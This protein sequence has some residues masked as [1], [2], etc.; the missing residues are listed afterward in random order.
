MVKSF[1]KRLASDIL[2]QEV[3]RAVVHLKGVDS[4]YVRMVELC[5]RFRFAF[6]SAQPIR[7]VGERLGQRLDGHVTIQPCVAATVHYPNAAVSD[8]M[9]DLV[10]PHSCARNERHELIGRAPIYVD[11]S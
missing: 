3:L 2:E 1:G 9:R 6:K 7:V 8:L 10:V 5:R 11:A 4:G